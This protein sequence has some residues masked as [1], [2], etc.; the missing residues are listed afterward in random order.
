MR[1]IRPRS[2]GLRTRLFETTTT[3]DTNYQNGRPAG[4]LRSLL[5]AGNYGNCFRLIADTWMDVVIHVKVGT[6]YRNDV[7]VGTPTVD[8][9]GNTAKFS[10]AQPLPK[11][12][13]VAYAQYGTDTNRAGMWITGQSGSTATVTRYEGSTAAP[14]PATAA[15]VRWIGHLCRDSVVE[16]YAGYQGEPILPVVTFT[17]WDLVNALPTDS[18]Q[19]DPK[20]GKLWFLSHATGKDPSI[21]HPTVDFWW[22]D[23][24]ISSHSLL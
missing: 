11:A 4:C 6:W 16:V 23:L 8:V 19:T 3:G 22:A 5:R 17:H 7:K 14:E 21:D 20:I 18:G 9:A 13:C 10:V 1:C 2:A 15:T 12:G 24:T